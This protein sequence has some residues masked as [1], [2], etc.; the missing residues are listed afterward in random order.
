MRAA[1]DEWVRKAEVDRVVAKRCA[2]GKTAL[3]EAV[4]FHSQQCAEKYLKALLEELGLS[5]PKT[6]NLVGLVDKLLGDHPSLRPL[7]RGVAFLTPFAVAVRYPGEDPT[8]R[9]AQ[10]ALRWM[11]HVRT[12]ARHLLG[13]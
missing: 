3:H 1:T 4:C 12:E 9:Q 13:I 10:A 8:R 7:K 2:R 5:V 11:E 6:H